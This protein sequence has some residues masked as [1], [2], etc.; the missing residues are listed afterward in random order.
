MRLCHAWG[1]RL[2]EEYKQS[3]S[4]HFITLTYATTNVPLTKRGLQSLWKR[5]VQLFF[6]R[7]R[8]AHSK[9][10]EI[11]VIKYFAVGEYGSRTH[12]PHY[13]VLLYNADIEKIQS[14]WGLGHVHYGNVDYPSVY[15]TLK[16]MMKRSPRKKKDARQK[17][18]R[19]M[20]KG[21][22]LSYAMNKKFI[23]WHRSDIGK[24]MYLNLSDGKKIGMPRYYKD[25]IFTETER[26]E[27][28]YAGLL[29]ARKLAEKDN[30]THEQK[31]QAILEA[32][33]RMEF[34]SKLRCGV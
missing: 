5:D 18:F 2:M 6:K 11:P 21:L 31:G 4:A 7:L 16:Y 8:K 27:A 32:Y 14:A 10:D 23:Q 13:H 26:E 1:F 24:R 12:R 22:G 3:S 9:C 34:E 33:F 25:K 20:S 29:R 15:Y 17:E 30:R 28:A 19:L